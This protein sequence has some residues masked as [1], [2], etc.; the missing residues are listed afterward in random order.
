[1]LQAATFVVL[2]VVLRRKY[3]I[4]AAHSVAFVL[5][6]QRG[7]IQSFLLLY[8]TLI[9]RFNLVHLGTLQLVLLGVALLTYPEN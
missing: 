1:M 4:S 9:L 5:E 3:G 6:R 8:M 7:S 2:Q